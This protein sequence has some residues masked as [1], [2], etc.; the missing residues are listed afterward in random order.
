MEVVHY[1]AEKRVEIRTAAA[2]AAVVMDTPALVKT[3]PAIAPTAVAPKP[4]LAPKVVE[5]G[6][7][8]LLP[9]EVSING[10]KSG[11]WLLLERGG[12]LYAPAG[13][14]EEWRLNRKA[15]AKSYNY[16]N[17]T[18]FPLTSVPFQAQLN[19][20]DQ[21][22]DIKFQSGAFAATRVTQAQADR[23]KMSPALPALFFNYDLSYTASDVRGIDTSKDLGAL[24]ELGFSNSLGVLTSSHVGR[25]LTNEGDSS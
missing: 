18:W 10:A 15:D 4:E 7:P 22:M 8:R 2:T 5:S 13:A 14:F 20:A 24:M 12:V 19:A 23:P 17:Q 25:N 6:A 11:N 9:L 16:R 3:E 21:S 1:F